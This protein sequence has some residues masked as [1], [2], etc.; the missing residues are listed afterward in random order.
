MDCCAAMLMMSGSKDHSAAKPSGTGIPHDELHKSYFANVV[1]VRD[2]IVDFARRSLPNA[3]KWID[4]LDFDT[5]EPM[6][7]E[8]VDEALRSRFNDMVWRLRFR[9]PD[10][11]AEW[12]YVIVMLEFQSTVDWLMALRVQ[13]YAV[14]IYESLPFVK[15][16]NSKTRLP[17]ILAIVVYNGRQP[18]RAAQHLSDLVGPGTRPA[19]PSPAVAPTFTGESYVLIDLQGL[20]AEDLPPNNVVSLLA[21]AHGMRDAEDLSRTFDEALRLLRGPQRAG[22]RK[23]FLEWLDQLAAQ[24]GVALRI[25]EVMSMQNVDAD[26]EVRLMVEERLQASLDKMKAQSRQEGRQEALEEG[27]ERARQEALEEGLERGRQEGRQEALGEALERA[28]Q[29]RLD[30]VR[31]MTAG[32]FGADTARRLDPLLV[33]IKDPERLSSV[34]DWIIACTTG[35]EL[36][37][38]LQHSD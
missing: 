6:P 9:D 14:R 29:E 5:L 15:S 16:P 33:E 7:T 31:R 11:D 10:P 38:R 22:L 1:A 4:R 13:I 34:F 3:D 24:I 28:R 8:T 32:R 21:Q 12:L 17:P 35:P 2:A 19:E 27:L 30:L 37:A 25:S 36:L 20:A 26:G 18:W 23:V